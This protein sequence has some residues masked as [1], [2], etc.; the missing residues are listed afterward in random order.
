MPTNKKGKKEEEYNLLIAKVN[1]FSANVGASVNYETYNKR[2][3]HN[4][5]RVFNFN[6]DLEILG[7]LSEPEERAGSSV[8]IEISSRELHGTGHNSLL[9]D[10]PVLD[11]DFQPQH[12][13]RNGVSSP[14]YN[15]PKS[16]GYIERQR[17]THI[18]KSWVW[19]APNTVSDMLTLLTS[20]QQLYLTIDEVKDGKYRRVRSITLQTT[21]PSDE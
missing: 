14:I 4:K 21:N 19:I 5:T 12:K 20:T 6:C 9:D 8:S 15:P 1:G 18:W 16:I 7:T 3:A 11:Q 17:G 2:T 10:Y 13:V